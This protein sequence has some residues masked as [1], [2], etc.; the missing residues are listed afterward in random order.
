M[1]AFINLIA[2]PAELQR[3]AGLADRLRDLLPAVL[4]AA[5][6]CGLVYAVYIGAKLAMAE[7]PNKRKEARRHAIT[8]VVAL[9]LVVFLLWLIPAIMD[10]AIS[11]IDF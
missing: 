7:D 10:F 3:F 11:I 1:R 2:L 8:F 4:I 9:V 5:V 6:S